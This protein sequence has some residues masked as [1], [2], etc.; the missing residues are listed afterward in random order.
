M[1]RVHCRR[2]RF[3]KRLLFGLEPLHAQTGG[4]RCSPRHSPPSVHRR[5]LAQR[6]PLLRGSLCSEDGQNGAVA[7]ISDALA[8]MHA[9]QVLRLHF[10]TNLISP[11]KNTEESGGR[12][13]P[14]SL[15]PD[16]KGAPPKDPWDGRSEDFLPLLSER[17][18]AEEK[19]LSHGR[20]PATR[21]RRPGY[22]FFH[23]LRQ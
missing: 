13:A 10:R 6:P 4:L 19:I 7:F 21:P 16:I 9:L 8:S 1:L 14:F 22:K 23:R 2:R 5:H 15:R 12:E 20:E 11:L 17:G 3:Q 18:A